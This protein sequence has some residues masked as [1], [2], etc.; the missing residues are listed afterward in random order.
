[1]TIQPNQ[2]TFVVAALLKTSK[3]N[4]DPYSWLYVVFL[5]QLHC[6]LIW[7]CRSIYEIQNLLGLRLIQLNCFC[8]S[9]SLIDLY[10]QI[11]VHAGLKPSFQTQEWMSPSSKDIVIGVRLRLR[12]C[13]KVFQLI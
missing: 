5:R 7:L 11:R 6:V 8:L 12:H 4:K 9:L 3:P 1:M 10:P 2:I 13:R